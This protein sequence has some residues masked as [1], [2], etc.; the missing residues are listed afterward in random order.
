MKISSH[1]SFGRWNCV[2]AEEGRRD[3]TANMLFLF[4]FGF[5]ECRFLFMISASS[6]TTLILSFSSCTFA[7]FCDG[8]RVVD[9]SVNSD[10]SL[11]EY[12]LTIK[13]RHFEETYLTTFGITIVP[14][15]GDMGFRGV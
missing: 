4:L 14:N 12:R 9:R 1:N 7:A 15:L 3:K 2:C 8:F 13:S 10:D 11:W 5:K 6:A